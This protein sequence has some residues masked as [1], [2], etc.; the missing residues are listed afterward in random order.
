M[1]NIKSP[2]DIMD[3]MS[4]IE[5]GWIDKNNNKHT[6]IDSSFSEN[7][8][9]QSPNEI[10]INK[11]G[12]CWDQVEFERECFKNLKINFKTFFIVHY[13]NDK[14]PTHTFLTYENNNKY[15]W[16]EHSWALFKGI[17]EYDTL[18][19]L[20]LDVKQKFISKDLN[21]NYN[22]N[23][24]VIYEYEKPQYHISTLEFYKHCEKGKFIKVNTFFEKVV[25]ELD[26]GNII[27]VPTRVSGG[28]T[29][30]MYKLFTDK[31]RYIIKLL[32]PNIMK[33]T[34]ALDNYKKADDLEEILKN[35]G[36]SAVYAIVF[37]NNKMQKID[38][39]YFYIYDW[40]DGKVLKDNEI[41]E[42]HVKTI[43]SLLAKIHN[44]N[45]I[46]QEELIDEKD[47]DWK[48]YIDLA[49]EKNSVIYDLIYDKLQ[50]L[51]DSMK[52]GNISIHRLPK[53]KSICH[54]DM[55]SKN[56]MWKDN[57]YKLIDLECLTYKNPYLELFELALCWSGY[58]K[59]DIDF[60][61]FKLFFESYFNNSKL[62]SNINWEDLYYSNNGRLEWLE[63]NI[64][65]A[66]MLECDTKEE[67]ELG[68]NEVK[69]TIEHIVYYDK[70]KNKIISNIEKI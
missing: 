26:L 47:I 44:I 49:K 51:N 48:Y 17:H 63:Y 45:L 23:N 6:T 30:K 37:N 16:F 38:G 69:V 58:E 57:D 19:N 22:N 61:L 4:D 32:N 27:E 11:I 68:I 31:S 40:Y 24:L 12:V 13:D 3:L 7:Y 52:N 21:Y 35:N 33:R 59:G 28:L 60:D 64:K 8:M 15:Y 36:V 62:E 39:Q 1:N 42:Y 53:V 70:I 29:H 55:D 18:E 46:N 54:N 10:K 65:R 9:L 56:V 2:E 5:Y 66:L 43:G 14:Y 50:I 25:S 41:D 34:T 67:Q 20:L